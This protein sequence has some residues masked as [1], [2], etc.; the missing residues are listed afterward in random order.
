MQSLRTRRPSE[1]RAKV[2]RAPTKVRIAAGSAGR[3]ATRVDDKIKKRM[4][5]RYADISGPTEASVPAVPTIPLGM[6]AGAPLSTSPEGIG[7]NE[8]M[9]ASKEEQREL[10]LRM[11][12]KEE[13]DPDAC[14]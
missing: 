7:L 11:L 8:R 5:M 2:Q 10:E 9:Q 14:T 1:S 13:F 12:D 4:S 6:R 3:R